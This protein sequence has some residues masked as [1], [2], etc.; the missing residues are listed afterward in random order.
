MAMSSVVAIPGPKNRLPGLLEIWDR[1][2]FSLATR[3]NDSP[4]RR[5]DALCG[6][7]VGVI[8]GSAWLLP[9]FS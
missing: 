6:S 2:M 4:N 1:H 7:S 8:G 9:V 3:E 5:R